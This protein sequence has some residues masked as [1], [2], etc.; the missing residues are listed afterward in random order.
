MSLI[1]IEIG[2]ITLDSDVQARMALSQET[3]EEYADVVDALPEIAVFHDGTTYWL[4]DGWH[5]VEAHKLAGRKVIQS[6]VHEGGKREA[7]LFAISANTMHGLR[8]TRADKRRAVEMLLADPEWSSWSNRAIAKKAGVSEGMVR[9]M[10][11]DCVNAQSTARTGADGRTIN[12]A[13]IGKKPAVHGLE[14]LTQEESERLAVIEAR[15]SEYE[16]QILGDA[17]SFRKLRE[18]MGPR[19]SEWAREHDD[20]YVG[21]RVLAGINALS[22][23]R[24]GE[25]FMTFPDAFGVDDPQ[26]PLFP[27]LDEDLDFATRDAMVH[28]WMTGKV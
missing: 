15:I 12:V 20:R 22:L 3:V 13:N 26:H 9:I 27:L 25:I 23:T 8:P 7:T 18:T 21:V 11:A 17:E 4:A 28:A 2:D 1:E 14:E 19:F 10:R 6:R 16:K 5:R 24:I